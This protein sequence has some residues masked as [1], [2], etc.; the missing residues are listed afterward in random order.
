[1]WIQEAHTSVAMQGVGIGSMLA[2][3][4][5][6]AARAAKCE[7]MALTVLTSNLRGRRHWSAHGF[8]RVA[9]VSVGIH[10]E[11]ETRVCSLRADGA[12]AQPGVG[13]SEAG[14]LTRDHAEL[15]AQGEV[16]GA[17]QGV[18]TS[19]SVGT[20]CRPA[21]A[22]QT[23]ASWTTLRSRSGPGVIR[24]FSPSSSSPFLY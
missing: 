2:A 17:G 6:A 22:R 4:A 21:K 10:N 15:G 16:R 14:A 20:T 23:H 18:S 5:K 11:L 24:C 12:F 9:N 8:D 1:M 3:F 13:I 7:V 19:G